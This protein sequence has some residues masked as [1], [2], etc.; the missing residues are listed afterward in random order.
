MTVRT[1][2]GRHRR[3]GDVGESLVELMVSVVIL[4]TTIV[5]VIEVLFMMIGGTAL[6]ADEVR[7]QNTLA[8][9]A[10]AVVSAPYTPCAQPS[11]TPA[12]FPAPSPSPTA[13]TT[14]VVSVEYWQ[15]S[16]FGA[17]CPTPDQGVQ[18]VTL[19]VVPP[20]GPIGDGGSGPTPEQTLKVVKRRPCTSGSGC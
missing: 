12:Q 18:L 9:W 15:G 16:G 5:V 10:D 20:V 8:S 7:G 11:A 1:A 3:G 13:F 6:Q 17:T 19:G 4:G 2:D 14:R